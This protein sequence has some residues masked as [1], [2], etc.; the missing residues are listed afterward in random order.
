MIV[1]VYT[2]GRR[3]DI[4]ALRQLA[5]DAFRKLVNEHPNTDFLLGRIPTVYGLTKGKD[6]T[7]RD[8]LVESLIKHCRSSEKALL[9][10]ADNWEGLHKDLVLGLLRKEKEDGKLKKNPDHGPNVHATSSNTEWGPTCGQTSAI[11]LLTLLL[12]I[13][14][15]WSIE[16]YDQMRIPAK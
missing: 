1:S 2:M 12:I 10:T 6:S 3:F 8:I 15:G 13:F 5:Q 4:P 9:K 14:I 7:I 16:V 11:V